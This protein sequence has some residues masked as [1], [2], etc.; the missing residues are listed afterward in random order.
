MTVAMDQ[1][2]SIPVCCSKALS[3]TFSPARLLTVWCAGAGRV[4]DAAAVGRIAKDHGVPFL[5]DA[6]QTVGQM[7]IDVRH[8]GCDWLSGTSRKYL[9]GPR[10]AG[11]LY[12][13]R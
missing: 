1:H 4:Y 9:R 12:A 2:N 5:L 6:C 7:P 13:S 10:G 8:I 3:G 11:F